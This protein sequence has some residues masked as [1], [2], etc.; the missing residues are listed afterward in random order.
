MPPAA[1]G[2][3]EEKM[4]PAAGG[5]IPPDPCDER[6]KIAGNRRCSDLSRVPE[7]VTFGTARP[8]LADGAAADV[9]LVRHDGVLDAQPAGII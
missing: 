9:R 8:H 6:N 7:Y 3:G 1:G 4:P 2:E 5:M